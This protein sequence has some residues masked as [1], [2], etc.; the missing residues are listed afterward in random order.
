MRRYI[1]GDFLEIKGLALTYAC[2]YGCTHCCQDAK[3]DGEKMSFSFVE[4]L[5]QSE[6]LLFSDTLLICWGEPIRYESE[7]RDL[8]DVVRL[9]FRNTGIKKIAINTNG[10]FSGDALAHTA[11]KKMGEFADRLL[12][13]LSFNLFSKKP[14]KLFE[15]S[16]WHLLNE[17]MDP[18]ISCTAIEHNWG[19][20]IEA[21]KEALK[22]FGYRPTEPIN[23]PTH[24]NPVV[25]TVFSS[26]NSELNVRFSLVGPVGRG[27]NV[28]QDFDSGT[29]GCRFLR[30]EVIYTIA[31][32]GDV[33][34]CLGLGGTRITPIGNVCENSAGEIIERTSEY[35]EKLVVF[36]ERNQENPNMPK[37]RCNRHIYGFRYHSTVPRTGRP[38]VL[39]G[40]AI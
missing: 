40:R 28:V 9:L 3:P 30:G 29:R 24:E 17:G 33:L 16:F 31:P 39:M 6:Q 18:T 23:M 11:L 37:F 15:H 10:F 38:A 21:L 12:F 1:M 4:K 26:S 35:W 20:T 14:T 25:S 19:R 7:G 2:G 5:A 22:I 32:N 27:M 13:S 8:G 34:P 36:F